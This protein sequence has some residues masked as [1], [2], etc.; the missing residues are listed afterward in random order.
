[1]EVTHPQECFH[2]ELLLFIIKLLLLTND[3][4]NL[5]IG[6]HKMDVPHWP[7]GQETELKSQPP[8]IPETPVKET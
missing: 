2:S 1:M 5:Y 8:L 4:V 7:G 6:T 3:N